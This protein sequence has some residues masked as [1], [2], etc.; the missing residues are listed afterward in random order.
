[1]Q[2]QSKLSLLSIRWAVRR[3]VSLNFWSNRM[4]KGLGLRFGTSDIDL[5]G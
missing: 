4:P 5:E 1:M 3:T 2:K